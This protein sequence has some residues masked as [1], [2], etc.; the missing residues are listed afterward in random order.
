MTAG[1]TPA[2]S[3]ARPF[4]LALAGAL[5]AAAVVR[6]ADPAAEAPRLTLDECVRTALANQPAI[7]AREGELGA[8]VA[9]QKIARSYMLP[10]A[11]VTTRFTQMDRHLFVNQPGL[12]GPSLD[13]FTDAAAFFSIARAAGPAA[14]NAALANPN[15]PPFS[16]AKEAALAVAPTNFQTNLLGERFLTTDVLVT[17][18]LYTGGKIRARN[19]Q[20][21][22]GIE[23][24]GQ[25]VAMTREQVV[26]NVTRA[27]Y[28]VLL[29]REV[30]R[31]AE[32]AR[33]QFR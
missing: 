17:Q 12:S 19:E 8:A 7:Q 28:G 31:V 4:T 30:A 1:G 11:G 20:A 5:L 26:Y 18:P 15:R 29:A 9:Q 23:A 13:I 16:T 27:Y 2:T 33:G 24:A 14:A 25:D 22:L 10:Q 3:L 6:S 32:E 21:K